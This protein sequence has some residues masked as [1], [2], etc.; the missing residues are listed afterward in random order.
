MAPETIS[1]NLTEQDCLSLLMLL[2][3]EANI[4]ASLGQFIAT[5][6]RVRPDLFSPV[7][8]EMHSRSHITFTYYN[9][10]FATRWARDRATSLAHQYLTWIDKQS[11]RGT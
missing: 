6:T 3:T 8:R 9:T 1:L 7:L 10:S 2:P 4:S 5:G 11:G